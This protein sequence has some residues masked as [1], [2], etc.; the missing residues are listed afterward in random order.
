MQ[1]LTSLGLHGLQVAILFLGCNRYANSVDPRGRTL[2]SHDYDENIIAQFYATIFLN[3]TN[4]REMIWM[5]R[6]KVMRATWAQFGVCL[7]LSD[8]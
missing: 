2:V 3:K 7:G 6:D 8:C 5:T 1:T 4:D